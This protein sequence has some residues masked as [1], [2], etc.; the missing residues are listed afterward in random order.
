MKKDVRGTTAA[1]KQLL[2]RLCFQTAQSLFWNYSLWRFAI[3]A[4]NAFAPFCL[5]I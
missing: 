5:T 2:Q 3:V 4:K 1:K